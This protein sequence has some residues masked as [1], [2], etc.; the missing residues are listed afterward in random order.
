MPRRASRA[1]K[2]AILETSRYNTR[3]G[4]S[5]EFHSDAAA[6]AYIDDMDA[7]ALA[8]HQY[9]LACER[10][11]ELIRKRNAEMTW[12]QWCIELLHYWTTNTN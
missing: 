4:S 11:K 8:A 1:R 2:Q 3:S 10:E 7:Q 12:C 5:Y 6:Q 9:Y